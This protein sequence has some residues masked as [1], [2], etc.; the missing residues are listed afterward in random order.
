MGSIR[1]SHQ[2]AA[3]LGVGRLSIGKGP[4]KPLR[5]KP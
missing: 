5:L 2:N 3:Q 4:M 1:R